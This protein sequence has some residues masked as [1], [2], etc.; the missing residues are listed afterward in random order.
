MSYE[1]KEPNFRAIPQALKDIPRWVTW[2]AE[3][4]SADEKPRKIPYDPKLPQTRASST[5]PDSWGTYEQAETA[6][7]DGDRTGIGFVLNNDG[8]V[9]VDIDNCIV[10]GEIHDEAIQILQW[11]GATYVERSPSGNG[12][13]SFGY[14]PP[15][16]RG[17]KGKLSEHLDV[18]VYSTG[19]YLTLTGDVVNDGELVAF[20]HF[21]ELAE[22][23]RTD[24]KVVDAETG[25]VYNQKNDQHAEL[26]RRVLSGDVYHDSLRDLAASFI[27][28]NMYGGAAVEQLRA[29]M[30]ASNAPR[31]D[32]WQARYNQIPALVR[33]AQEKFTPTQYDLPKI[34]PEIEQ[35]LDDKLGVVCAANLPSEFEPPDELVQ[36]LLTCGSLSVFYGDSNSGKTFCAV[37][38]SCAISRGADWMERKT[39]QG[40]VAYMATESANSVLTR[41]KA[42]Q[43]YHKVLL[44]N[45]YVFTRPVN[46][47]KD[48]ADVMA[49]VEMMKK[50]EDER[51]MPFRLVVGDT[52]ARIASG[53]NENAGTDM[54][55]VMERFDYLSRQTKAHTMLI[56]HNGKDV[57][58]GARGWSGIRA[59][60]DTEIE[61]VEGAEGVRTATITKQRELGGKNNSI[62][63]KLHVVEMGINKW[64]DMATTCV[65]L[66]SD[67][68]DNQ[69]N[70]KKE[71]KS[72]INAKSSFEG[73]LREY[74]YIDQ[75]GD[76]FVTADNWNEYTIKENKGSE[77]ARRQALSRAKKELI[78]N[79]L[80]VEK[81]SGYAAT[82]HP[83]WTA[84]R[85]SM[86]KKA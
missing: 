57:A 6:Y 35:S 14:A 51:Q 1:Y 62:Y 43:E 61:I 8:I 75:D 22:L 13:R 83:D 65:V 74:G 49:V 7:H 54:S 63:F 81:R 29:L 73:A 31:D 33:S 64:G 23:L 58:R 41:L 25:E 70:N 48:S 53:A 69:V 56:H 80:A 24:R 45:V 5:D 3:A 50:I 10:N 28:N 19:R 34:V 68:P 32:R 30:K 4:A 76:L 40:L 36:G 72:L 11:L 52:L 26:I 39:E 84:V 20:D 21:D 55:P 37:D 60:I 2:R 59:H 44:E 82:R 78:E 38:L 86:A 77:G 27:S 12:L 47:F 9:G 85:L 67:A 17:A 71:S 18:E 79:E 16:E 15:L 46:F 42:Y 66:P